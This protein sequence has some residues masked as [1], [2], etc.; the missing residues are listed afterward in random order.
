MAG[1]RLLRL[2]D[3]VLRICIVCRRPRS[4]TTAEGFSYVS[5]EASK[6]T[7]VAGT[8]SVRV[9]PVASASMRWA[10]QWDYLIEIDVGDGDDPRALLDSPQ[11]RDVL[12]D[13]RLLGMTPT[14]A[15]LDTET[16]VAW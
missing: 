4:G 7:S 8:R 3:G 2:P 1:E 13:L 11:G 16:A 5:G 10:R 9:F 15:V 14:V 12:G 6:L